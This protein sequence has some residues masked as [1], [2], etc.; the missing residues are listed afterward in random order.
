MLVRMCT[1]VWLF[2]WIQM[3]Y[4]MWIL[5]IKYVHSSSFVYPARHWIVA[6]RGVC[7]YLDSVAI[8]QFVVKMKE[9]RVI[10]WNPLLLEWTE[11]N[12][13]VDIGQNMHFSRVAVWIQMCYLKL[14]EWEWLGILLLVESMAL[15]EILGTC[16]N[17]LMRQS[18]EL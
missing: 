11:L 2:F 4:V 12:C 5:R 6:Y 17:L 8:F 14:E 1:L 7:D 10:E 3:W 18:G 13:F 15:L 16:F 9:S